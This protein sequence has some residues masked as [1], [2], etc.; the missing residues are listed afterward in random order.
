MRALVTGGTGFVGSHL[1][2]RLL[3]RDWQVRCLVRAASRLDNLSELPVEFATGDLRDVDS[4]KQAVR[5]VDVVYHC[6]A[7]YRLWCAD[8][9]EMYESNVNGSRNVMQA[10]LDERVERVVYTSTVGALGLKHDGTPADEETPVSIA[11]MIGHYKRSKFL[12]EEEV[13]GFAARGLPV[14]IVNPSTPVGEL[15][16]KPTPTGKIIVDF[17][18]GK[19]F[20]YVDTGMNLIDVR[21]CAEG[22]ILAAER[23]R[24][25]ER[26]ILGGTNLTLKEMFDA[27]ARVTEIASPRMKVP[28]WV[29]ESYARVENFWAINIARRAPDVPV[30]SVRMSRHRMW[31]DS[32]KAV[33]EL[34]LP[35]NPIDDALAR[36]VRWFNEHGYVTR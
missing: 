6:A 12:A 33:R 22:H 10:A 30:E 14:V 24:T 26:Y 28:H 23:G 5:G 21:D 27:L 20:G 36:A 11:D 16:I 7:D 15:D 19:M 4:I 18:K 34:G 32:S 35:Q 29:A 3:A 17:L 31:F 8:P 9:R 13:R 1:V 2:R 25:G